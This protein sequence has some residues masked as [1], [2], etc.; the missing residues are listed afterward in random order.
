MLRQSS[1]ISALATLV[2]GIFLMANM[3]MA[4][5]QVVAWGSQGD[6]G[7]AVQKN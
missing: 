1:K 5:A 3:Q 4:L 6:Q 7:S 2:I